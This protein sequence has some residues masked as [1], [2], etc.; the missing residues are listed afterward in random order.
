MCS[1]VD[2]FQITGLRMRMSALERLYTAAAKSPTSFKQIVLHRALYGNQSLRHHFF[3]PHT[4][5]VL[6]GD[7]RCSA[8]GR[9]TVW[10]PK[11]RSNFSWLRG[12]GAQVN[13]HRG[14]RIVVVDRR[15]DG[16]ET[17]EM[18]KT[19]VPLGQMK[20]ALALPPVPTDHPFRLHF[21]D[22]DTGRVPTEI[23]FMYHDYA[24]VVVNI[25]Q[26]EMQHFLDD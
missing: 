17:Y 13:I 6:G 24:N 3:L 7:F 20:D 23:Q 2:T 10:S 26:V 11:W 9:L 1:P 15:E 21:I 18:R 12:I 22:K 19:T 8:T 16:S 5:T 25:G 4:L 14:R